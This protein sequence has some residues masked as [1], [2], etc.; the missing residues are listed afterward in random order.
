M[1]RLSHT[2]SKSGSQKK[3]KVKRAPKRCNYCKNHV[4][5]EVLERGHGTCEF[6]NHDHFEK[7]R[8]CERNYNKTRIARKF[9]DKKL[10]EKNVV[11]SGRRRRS[12]TP[13]KN[14][15]LKEIIINLESQ[16]DISAVETIMAMDEEIIGWNGE[17]CEDLFVDNNGVAFSSN[18][19]I[20][21]TSNFLQAFNYPMII[22]DTD[23]PV[24]MSEMNEQFQ[25]EYSLII[26]PTTYPNDI[27]Y[28]DNEKD[29]I[30]LIENVSEELEKVNKERLK[31]QY[32]AL[33]VGRWKVVCLDEYTRDLFTHEVL[34]W[35]I[36][37][38]ES[39]D[40]LKL[41]V[42]PEN[43]LP[44]YIKASCIL[45]NLINEQDF[46]PS[47]ISGGQLNASRWSVDKVEPFGEQFKVFFGID[48]KSYR[49]LYTDAYWL[50]V[51]NE[52]VKVNIDSNPFSEENSV[53]NV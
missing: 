11:Q 36:K 44:R 15:K 4:K 2:R 42:I 3:T 9:R 12:G 1:A 50:I 25:N 14:E 31:I 10:S 24:N 7:C 47:I 33:E 41:K 32:K 29:M 46:L 18:N 21:D 40:Y 38:I 39:D 22:N 28:P 19:T 16:E 35:D 26:L 30:N 34:K 13:D 52:Y 23:F 17:F 27:L 6:N 51:K 49:Y 20:T 5:E 53:I 45:K 48:P 8:P 37:K 43:K